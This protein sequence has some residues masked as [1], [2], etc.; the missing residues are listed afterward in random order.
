[1]SKI[2]QGNNPQTIVE[3]DEMNFF[4][5][6]KKEKQNPFLGFFL[7]IE[8]DKIIAYLLYTEIYDR[9]EIE[10]FMVLDSFRNHGIGTQLLQKLIEYA[11]DKQLQNITLEVREDNKSALHLYRKMGFQEVSKRKGYYQGIDGI[12]MIKKL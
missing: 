6:W 4:T 3:K 12:L 1:M 8:E 5:L 2:I 7:S 9:I 10:Q 11:T